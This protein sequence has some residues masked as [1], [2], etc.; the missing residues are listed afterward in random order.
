V[1]NE[2]YSLRLGRLLGVETVR[3]D[4]SRVLGSEYLLVERYDRRIGEQGP[5][6]LHQEDFCQALGIPTA[7]STRRREA[8]D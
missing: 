4:P 6:R 8:R 1:A 3:A 7:R 5:E 2:A